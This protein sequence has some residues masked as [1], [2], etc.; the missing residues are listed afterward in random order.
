MVQVSTSPGPSPATA[1]CT[2]LGWV[3]GFSGS[4]VYLG[5]SPYRKG[6]LFPS[7][8]LQRLVNI[9][10]ETQLSQRLPLGV[11]VCLLECT[12]QRDGEELGVLANL[13][14]LHSRL[15]AKCWT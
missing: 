5:V 13:F 12:G 14:F 1:S 7:L 10:Q 3:W 2:L 9:I 4:V 15:A 6:Q 11:S 8:V